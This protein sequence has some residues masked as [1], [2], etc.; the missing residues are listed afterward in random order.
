MQTVRRW[1]IVLAGVGVLAAGCSH[2]DQG[3]RRAERAAREGRG[4]V[5]GAGEGSATVPPA[6]PAGAAAVA[7]GGA[8]ALR[9]TRPSGDSPG[10]YDAALLE[11]LGRVAERR[12]PEALAALERA[13]AEQDTEQVRDEMS[14]VQ[15]L[16]AQE[17]VAEKTAAD[18]QAVLQ[19]GRVEEG[20]RLA[21]AA[22]REFGATDAAARIAGLKVQADALAAADLEKAARRTR[23]RQEGDA[24]LRDGNL[25]GAEVALARALQEGDESAREPLEGVRASLSSYD[26]NRR[27]AAEFRRDLANLEEAV[28]ALRRAAAAW[29]TVEVRQEIEEYTLA[30]QNR[31]DRV[32]V[33]DFEV[34]GETGIPAAGR[35]VAEELLPTLR[36]RFEVVEREQL[37]RLADELKIDASVLAGNNAACR[38]LG[39]AGRVRYLVV[40]SV[41]SLCGV[42]V[43]ARLVEVRSGLVVQTAKLV[44]ATPEEAIRR[45]PEL[46]TLLLMT[47]EQRMAYETRLA[48]RVVPAAVAVAEAP[49]P[50]APVIVAAQPPPPPVVVY[51]PRPPDFGGLTPADFACLQA[52]ASGGLGVTL[53]RDDPIK[54]RLLRVAVELGDNLFLRGRYREAHAQFQLALSLHPGHPELNLRVDRCRPYV[55]AP[56]PAAAGPAPVVV[57]AAPVVVA[58]ARPRLVVLNFLVSADPGRTPPGLG[59]WAADQLASYYAPSYEVVDRGA[60]FWYMG[61]LGLSVRD[62][63]TNASARLC[64]GRALDTRWF[65]FGVV[66][67][68]ASFTVTTHL[69]DAQ[70]NATSK[71]ASIHV[72]D[73]QELKLRMGELVRQTTADAAGAAALQ[74]ETRESEAR[75]NEARRLVSAGQYARAANVCKEGLKARPDNVALQALLAEADRKD[76]Q[77]KLVE[78]QR[79][80]QER[81]RALAAEARRRQEELARQAEETRQRAARAAA[82]Q[83]DARQAEERRRQQA[84]DQ[85]VASAREALGR[86]DAA[87]SARLLESAVA[88]KSDDATRQALNAARSKAEEAARAKAAAEQAQREAALRRQREDALARAKAEAA[89]EVEVRRLAAASRPTPAIKPVADDAG[90]RDR[91]AVYAKQMQAAAA[92]EQKKQFAEAARAYREA[93]RFLPGEARAAA[94]LRNAEFQQHLAAGRKALDAKQYA[95]AGHEFEEALKLEPGN[96]EAAALLQRARQKR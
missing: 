18:I 28:E 94:G 62:V 66:Q 70:T 74:T 51:T 77:A 65:V 7:V 68:T 84:H 12:Y 79:R 30:L 29:D 5:P 64:L 87:T 27:R 10:R 49:L 83:R 2:R 52:P 56:A 75:V 95:A 19:Q 46:S 54:Q 80:L 43:N 72:Q 1:F 44:A 86:G 11:A 20:V 32:A 21:A 33:A 16:V 37:G 73:H 89:K 48:E 58:P 85:L 35:T 26:E 15:R 59:D 38:A 22:L 47:D 13:R 93:L 69:V 57:A 61:R 45:L 6:A 78:E 39:E 96:A 63:L 9:V 40:G 17:A 42:T 4:G 88:L 53:E 31:R 71:Q 36:P 14:R 23:F 34:R 50:P 41:S 92:C 55:A 76:Q 25:R 60:V 90:A 81:T 67:Q 91:M 3:E 82:A 24:A 8:E